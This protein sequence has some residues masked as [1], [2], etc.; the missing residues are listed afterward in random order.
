MR[1]GIDFDNTI[2]SYDELFRRVAVEQQLVPETIPASKTEVRNYLRKIGREEAWTAMQGVVYGKRMSEAKAF[3]GVLDFILACHRANI[4]LF[5]A[6]H[7]T[8]FPIVGEQFD[9]HAAAREWLRLQ[10]IPDFIPSDSIHFELTKDAKLSRI[11]SRDPTHFIDDLPEF[12]TMPGF[13]AVQR[14]LFDPLG[15]SVAEDGI[16]PMTSWPGIQKHFG[17]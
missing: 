11:K 3:P 8:K 14:I 16:L 17:L 5:I 1:I 13:P 4:P 7:R 9:L 15:A 6:S 10:G 12:L 2:V